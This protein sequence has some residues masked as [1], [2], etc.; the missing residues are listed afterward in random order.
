[1]R[2]EQKSEIIHDALQYLDDELIEEVDALRNGTMPPKQEKRLRT[3][4]L[5]Q[6]WVAV[7]ASIC[8]IILAGSIW[9]GSLGG[10]SSS[11][12]GVH[13]E[14]DVKE[15]MQEGFFGEPGVNEEFVEDNIENLDKEENDFFEDC[16]NMNATLD[17]E[18]DVE[19]TEDTETEE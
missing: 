1:M 4:V 9:N 2:E 17:K 3:I 13:D 16:E 7:A 14:N 5:K 18:E 6:K 10:F 11:G 19:S 8:L 12:E 15:N